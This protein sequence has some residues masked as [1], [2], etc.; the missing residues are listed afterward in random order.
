MRIAATR[1]WRDSEPRSCGLS[2]S[3]IAAAEAVGLN[4]EWF[5]LGGV[6]PSRWLKVVVLY[7]RELGWVV[8][9]FPRRSFP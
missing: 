6:G 1:N 4:E 9:A 8:T 7:E 2:A 3:P 5:Y